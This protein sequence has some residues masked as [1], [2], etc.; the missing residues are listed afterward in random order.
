MIGLFE[1]MKQ[2]L[3]VL[4]L[5]VL[6][7]FSI[8]QQYKFYRAETCSTDTIVIDNSTLK[9]RLLIDSLP[10]HRE[11]E[12]SFISDFGIRFELGFSGFIYDSNTNTW[13]TNSPGL[14][15][16][17]SLAFR[18]F[19]FGVR[20]K[21]TTITPKNNLVFGSDTLTNNFYLNPN[22]IDYYLGYS[23]DFDHLISIEPFAAFSQNIFSVINESDYNKTFSIPKL[24][25]LKMGFTFN[26]YFKKKEFYFFTVFFN[27]AYSIVDFSKVNIELG[28]GYHDFTLGIAYKMY[29][30]WF[31][32][33]RVD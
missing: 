7:N 2:V 13:L 24:N 9:R 10:T 8:G 17:I 15:G 25:G 33:H 32:R 12:C 11:I 31:E 4:L 6:Y 20:F 29:S 30:K 3:T 22:K 21:T 5:I 27:Y 28:K 26:K 19:N 23:L 14:T 16:G 18:Q 1:F